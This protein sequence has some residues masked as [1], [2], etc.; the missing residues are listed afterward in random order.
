MT[1]A[2]TKA[3]IGLKNLSLFAIVPALLFLLTYLAT[4]FELLIFVN[5]PKMPIHFADLALIAASADCSKTDSTW[6]I[7]S[8]A[9]DPYG[10]EINYYS[11]VPKLSAFLGLTLDNVTLVGWLLTAIFCGTLYVAILTLLDYSRLALTCITL[12]MVSPP[13]FLLLERSNSDILIFTLVLIGFIFR[14]AKHGAVSLIMFLLSILIKP[15]SICIILYLALSRNFK[16]IHSLIFI[17]SSFGILFIVRE[18]LPI[19]YGRTYQILELSFG[20]RQ[21][22]LIAQ[23]IFKNEFMPPKMQLVYIVMIIVLS[24]VTLIFYGKRIKTSIKVYKEYDLLLF[25]S[26]VFVGVFSMGNSY[27]T[28]LWTLLPFMFWLLKNSAYLLT[29]LFSLSMQL[30]FLAHPL[31]LFLDLLLYPVVGFM[32]SVILIAMQTRIRELHYFK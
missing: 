17:A 6:S 15:F 3:Q 25:S 30:S 4:K 20:P 7:N 16:G 28:R 21:L 23:K 19:M 2:Q 18:D 22:F 27:D 12:F 31:D 26:V 10:R 24:L 32:G 11:I 1:F 9:C 14:K 5:F 8:P 13:I 29:L